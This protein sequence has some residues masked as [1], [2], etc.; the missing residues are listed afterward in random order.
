METN[1]NVAFR[2]DRDCDS[3]DSILRRHAPTV[4]G[5]NLRNVAFTMV[6]VSIFETSPQRQSRNPVSRSCN[7]ER[8]HTLSCSH[9][10]AHAMILLVRSL[11]SVRN[12][13]GEQVGNQAI[14]NSKEP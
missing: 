2:R 10:V 13:H 7:R 12:A 11:S 9:V 6:W 1:A 8:S 3:S 4:H 5:S 14:A